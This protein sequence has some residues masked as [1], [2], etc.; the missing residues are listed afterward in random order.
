[1]PLLISSRIT[2]AGLTASSSAS[3][4][5]VIVV[6]SSIAPRSRGSIVWTADCAS[7]GRRGGLRGPRR[8]RVPLLLL[9]THSSFD[10]QCR[11][12]GRQRHAQVVR[13]RCPER[14]PEGAAPDG[15]GPA[16]GVPA[17][18]GSPAGQPAGFVDLHLPV[19]GPDDP[20]EVPLGPGRATGDARPGRDPPRRIPTGRRYFATSLVAVFRV[21]VFFSGSAAGS[22]ASSGAVPFDEAATAASVPFDDAAA[23]FARGFAGAAFAGAASTAAVSVPFDAAADAFLAL[24]RGF[25][26]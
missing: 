10:V 24:A 15:E 25:F 21:R 6:G 23:F 9:A 19:G 14:P 13:N 20:D 4:L 16:A 18:V 1:M 17:E 22:A 8:P 3:S 2:S 7:P 11:R 12:P 26:A 5:T